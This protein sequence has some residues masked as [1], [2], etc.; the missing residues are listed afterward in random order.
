MANQSSSRSTERSRLLDVEPETTAPSQAETPNDDEPS[1][2]LYS[3]FQNADKRLIVFL[4]ATAGFFSPFSAFIYFP[5]LKSI[6]KSLGV[7]MELMDLTVTMYLV[8]QGIVPCVTGELS[9]NIG[10][11]PTYLAVFIIYLVASIG[12]SIQ[13]S[14]SALLAL[15][16]LQSVGSSG[17]IALAYGV[18]A[19]VAP[20]HERGGYVGNAHIGFNS[21]TSLGPVVGGLLTGKFGWRSIFW[22]L[23]M[24]S[25]IVFIALLILLPETSRNL[26]GNGNIQAIGIDKSFT[27]RLR[28][29][30][31]PV[32]SKTMP[33]P[34]M[35]FPNILPCL[36]LI[37]YKDTAIVLFSNAVFYMKYSCIQASLAP[38]LQ[39]TY[40]LGTLEVGFCYLAFGSAT[41]IASYGVGK[42]A[43]YDYQQVARTH[44]LVIDRARG[45]DLSKF[46]IEKAR[47]RTVWLYIFISATATL[48]YGWTLEHRTHLATPLSMQFLIGLAV[49]GVFNVCNTL[50]VDL[51]SDQA[52]TASA[53]VSI[54]RCASAAAGVSVL[55]LLLDA[56]G[57]GW[58][59]TIIAGLCYGIAPLLW[60]ERE[61]GW[62][63]RL[64][65]LRGSDPSSDGRMVNGA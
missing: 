47:L 34:R 22:L 23:A 10:R 12:L 53:S 43:D 24:F 50:V 32:S 59:F 49:T 44:H 46:P 57:L 26:V 42:S 13:N 56:I 19:D 61:K 63:W 38:L 40:G 58:T 7:T 6:S 52:A 3:A 14:Y 33:K 30:K 55:Q 8:V 11:R 65:R 60:L 36:R 20:P 62:Q 51:H 16:M 41:A 2:D 35:K 64:E 27:D 5:A 17:T 29:K 39:D 1:E 28:K 31:M 15:R 37:F 9:E 4:I 21:A 25:G 54:T 18:I 48:G 45:D